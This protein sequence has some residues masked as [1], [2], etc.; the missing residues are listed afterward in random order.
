[1]LLREQ[2]KWSDHRLTPYFQPVALHDI[3]KLDGGGEDGG[4]GKWATFWGGGAQVD[5]AKWRQKGQCEHR[6]QSSCRCG[7][8][9]PSIG[10]LFWVKVPPG[11]L[12]FSSFPELVS[13]SNQQNFGA[14]CKVHLMEVTELCIFL[15]KVLFAMANIPLSH[16]LFPLPPP[17]PT[18]P[19]GEALSP[20]S[21]DIFQCNH[22][23]HSPNFTHQIT[24]VFWSNWVITLISKHE[25]QKLMSLESGKTIYMLTVTGKLV[26]LWPSVF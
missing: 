2:Y 9:G 8:Q 7:V 23:T 4:H 19:L 25:M 5:N 11:A 6:A 14:V 3:L 21:W 15:P 13:A 20:T 10:S 16:A 22:I 24:S 12:Q 18:T 17:H 26:H 1:M